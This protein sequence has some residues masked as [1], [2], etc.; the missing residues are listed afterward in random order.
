[1]KK[2][3]FLSLILFVLAFTINAQNDT[4]YIMKNGVVAGKFNVN[5]QVDSVIFY[6]PISSSSTTVTDFDGNVYNT[7][8]IGSQVWMAENLKTTHY[9]D[10]TAIPL[11]T[12]NSNWDTLTATSK[13]YCWYNDDVINKATYGAL[14][15]WAAAMNGAASVTTNPSGVQGVCPTGWHLPSDAEWTQLTDYLGGTGV[16]GGKL[17]ESGTTH[18]TSPNTGATNETGFTALPGGYRNCDGTFYVIGDYG[19]WW[20]SEELDSYSA[21]YRDMYYDTSYVSRYGDYK[22]VGFSVRC[23]R[24]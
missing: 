3:I 15:T 13:A 17:K 6:K 1:M 18:W 14:Y 16:A 21:Y 5:N 22:E 20:V 23:L 10:G 12:G 19:L 11:V 8:T 9:S 4:M 2:S 24:D 7:I